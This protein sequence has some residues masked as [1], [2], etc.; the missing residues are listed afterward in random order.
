VADLAD[1][2]VDAGSGAVAVAA[3]DG[4]VWIRPAGGDWA[5]VLGP[6]SR[7]LADTSADELLLG[8]E[9]RIDEALGELEEPD[10]ADVD[11]TDTGDE[12]EL[13]ELLAEEAAERMREA[14]EDAAEQARADL[15]VERSEDDR[16]RDVGRFARAR[17]WFEEGLVLVGR[18]DG[19]YASGDALAPDAERG[20]PTW[21]ALLDVPVTALA[22]VGGVRVVGTDDGLLAAPSTPGELAW[23]VRDATLALEGVAV[24]D[25]VPLG[26]DTWMACSSDGAWVSNDGLGWSSVGSRGDVVLSALADPWLPGRSWVSRLDG[27]RVEVQGSLRPPGLGAPPAVRSLAAIGPDH[28]LAAGPSG[29]RESIDGGRTWMPLQRGLFDRDAR[30]LALAPNGVLLAGGDGLLLL[31]PEPDDRGA[32]L[33]PDWIPL[34]QLVAAASAR[35]GLAG[36]EGAR[37]WATALPQLNLE[38]RYEP[39]RRIAYTGGQ[40]GHESEADVYV[41]GWLTWK[42]ERQGGAAPEAIVFGDEVFVDDGS[43]P[44]ML[45][46]RI[47]RGQAAYSGEVA[48][49]IVALYMQRQTLVGDRR[50]A[51][52]RGLLTR[53]Q[54]ELRIREVEARIDALTDGVVSAWRPEDQP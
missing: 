40:S 50:E 11:A 48:H 28:L 42:P 1:V 23:D 13:E 38:G 41:T 30:A 27:V 33:E 14:V 44:A 21:R 45:A 43:D 53:V 24:A 7:E 3:V 46:A 9:A 49:E 29:V 47:D 26:T 5:Q 18:S 54:H 31:V 12:A 15:T 6:G 19:L 8:V 16:R 32:P 20:A 34:P 37:R 4:A 36:H 39:D 10:E 52:D 35:A 22:R 25:L 51:A 2:A 17:V